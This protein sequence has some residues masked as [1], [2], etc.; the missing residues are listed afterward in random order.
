MSLPRFDLTWK[1]VH[2]GSPTYLTSIDTSSIRFEGMF[3]SES[4]QQFLPT[5]NPPLLPEKNLRNTSIRLSSDIR[6]PP[7]RCRPSK[8]QTSGS[9]QSRRI[10]ILRVLSD[11]GWVSMRFGRKTR[12]T[13]KCSLQFGQQTQCSKDL[14]HRPNE[15][16]IPYEVAVWMQL[17]PTEKGFG[18]PV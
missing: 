13:S 16:L 14:N 6:L 3:F 15:T 5:C 7:E 4:Q 8:D 11:A 18:A 17:E 10:E 2:L 9:S 12:V 1:R